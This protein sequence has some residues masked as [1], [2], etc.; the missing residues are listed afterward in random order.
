MF[1]DVVSEKIGSMRAISADDVLAALGLQRRRSFATSMLPIASG[2]AAG[3]LAGAAVALLFAPKEGKEIRR[4]IA[5][6]ASDVT[7]RVGQAADDMI[8]EVKNALPLATEKMEKA[9][10]EEPL[11]VAAPP[12]PSL[13]EENGVGHVPRYSPPAK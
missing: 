12:R 8:N 2:F 10:K 11:A 6:T 13:R 3:A 1:Q 9:E 4:Q 5:G 7:R